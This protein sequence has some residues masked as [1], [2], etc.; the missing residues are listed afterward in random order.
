MSTTDE[1]YQEVILDHNRRP[2][3]FGALENPTHQAEGYNPLC[4]DHYHLY[5]NLGPDGT[6]QDVGFTG[7]GCA[8]SKASLSIMA[9]ALEGKSP[10]QARVLFEQ[11]HDLVTGKSST[12]EH[13][14]NL[15]KLAVF[16]GITRFPTRV[17]CAILGWHALLGALDQKAHPI[18]T[19]K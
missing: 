11:F 7:A 14:A 18:S 17:K 15:G 3:H 4:G 9:E 19:E 2:R 10:Q 8:I 13:T 5:L 16:S 12:S 1:L 6:I